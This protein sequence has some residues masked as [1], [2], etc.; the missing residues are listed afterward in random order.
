MI[1]PIC[2][3]PTLAPAKQH[4]SYDTTVEKQIGKHL[5]VTMRCVGRGSVAVESRA[6]NRENVFESSCRRFGVLA[7]LFTPRC[8][9]SLSRINEC[10]VIDRSGHLN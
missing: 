5:D 7:I 4:V 1:T 3:R 8:H 9:S 6:L 2:L 10:L